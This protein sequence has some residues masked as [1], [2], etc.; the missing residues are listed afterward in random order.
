MRLLVG[1][2]PQIPKGDGEGPVR[3]YVAAMPEWKRDVGHR[4][5][6]LITETV[7]GVHKAVR[8]N[9]PLYGVE[10]RGWFASFVLHP[11]REGDLLSRCAAPASS[12]RRHAQERRRPSS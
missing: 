2:N 8:W 10:G 12:A 3:A 5:D 11:L 9:Q 6:R 7:P 4:L 1:G